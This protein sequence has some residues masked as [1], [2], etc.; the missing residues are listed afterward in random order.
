MYIFGAVFFAADVEVFQVEVIFAQVRHRSVDRFDR[1][2]NSFL[3][4]VLLDDDRV[5]PQ[6]GLELDVIDCLEIGRVDNAEEQSL[7]TLDERQHPMLVDEFLVDRP[8]AVDV[9]F[10]GVEVHQRHA[11]LV[12]RGYCNGPGVGNVL[13]DEIGDERH[14]VFLGSLARLGKLCLGDDTV[15]YQSPRQSRQVSL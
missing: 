3:K 1:L 15:L 14:L 12:R 4:L 5:D 11:E 7:A 8:K 9:Q 6:A 13:V 2:G 10:D